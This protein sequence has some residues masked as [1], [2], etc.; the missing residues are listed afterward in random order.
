MSYLNDLVVFPTVFNWSLN[1]SMRSS[2]SEPQS[3]LG[4]IFCWLY[5]A[6]PSTVAKNKNQSEFSTDH[7]M[8]SMCRVICCVFGRGCLLWPVCSFGKTLFSLCPASFCM[9]R[10]N[11]TVT[12]DISWFPTFAF[13]FPIMKRT[14][15]SVSVLEGL[16]GPHR[17]VQLSFFTITAW[18]I[19]L[20]YCDIK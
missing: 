9:P 12:L 16:W 11:L 2:W 13:Q 7:L 17:T 6:S 20:D 1:F 8:M 15:Y 10:P 3:T 4:L 18:D 19:T 5:R 14:F